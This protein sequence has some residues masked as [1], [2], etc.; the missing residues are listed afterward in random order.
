MLN[1]V[2]YFFGFLV[3]GWVINIAIQRWD[4]GRCP[5]R[6]SAKVAMIKLHLDSSHDPWIIRRYD[7]YRL[8][9]L[10]LRLDRHRQEIQRMSQAQPNKPLP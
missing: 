8:R 3:I 1:L 2:G 10:T 9:R 7:A 6:W 4:E 5:S